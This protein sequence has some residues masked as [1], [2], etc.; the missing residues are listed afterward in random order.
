MEVARHEKIAVG[1]AKAT[2][3][4]DRKGDQDGPLALPRLRAMLAAPGIKVNWFP[5]QQRKQAST[6]GVSPMLQKQ[7]PFWILSPDFTVGEAGKCDY[8]IK[9]RLAVARI[10]AELCFAVPR[11]VSVVNS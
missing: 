8:A 9:M 6:Q 5:Q 3:V 7:G 4:S 2:R 11:M 1:L 10:R